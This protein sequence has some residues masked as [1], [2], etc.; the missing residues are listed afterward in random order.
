MASMSLSKRAAN[1]ARITLSSSTMG[2]LV[3][4]VMLFA[5]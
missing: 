5:H 3:S 4:L 2:S 1:L